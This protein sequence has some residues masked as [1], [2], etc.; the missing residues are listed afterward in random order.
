MSTFSADVYLVPGKVV[1]NTRFDPPLA[2]FVPEEDD[3]PELEE[4]PEDDG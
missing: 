2:A 4:P 1:A 3:L